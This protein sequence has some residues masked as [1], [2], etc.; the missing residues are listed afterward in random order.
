M[1]TPVAVAIVAVAVIAVIAVFALGLRAAVRRR[2]LR[3]RFGTEYD[4]ILRDT[5]SARKTAAE[6]AER[7]RRVRGLDLRPLTSAARTGFCSRWTGVQ[8]SFVDQPDVAV[9]SAQRLVIDV[10]DERGYPTADQG[11]LLADLSVDHAGAVERYRSARELSDSS[12]GVVSTED[13]RQAL[14]HYRA[15]FD[16][17]SAAANG[18][19]NADKA[20]GQSG[21]DQDS[22]P[23]DETSSA[24]NR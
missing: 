5:K 20:A 4:R 11:Q 8:E 23:A 12:N 7:E 1:P 14:I 10:L 18:A 17:L 13:L 22:K 24:R 6:L 15:V 16:G 9:T 21:A 2:E 3:K 19:G